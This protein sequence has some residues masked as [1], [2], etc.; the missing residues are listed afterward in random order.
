LSSY[1]PGTGGGGKD[2]SG[3]SESGLQEVVKIIHLLANSLANQFSRRYQKSKTPG[4]F[5]VRKTLRHNMRSGG[6]IMQLHFQKLQKQ[7]LHLILLCDVSKSM[8]LYS[9]F[10]VQFLYAFQNN[11]RQ[12]ETFVFSTSLHR[13][14]RELQKGDFEDILEQLSDQVPNWS[15]GTRIGASLHQFLEDHAGKHLKHRSIVLILS[16]GWD[17]GEVDLLADSMQR[18]K[19]KAGRIIWLNPLAGRPGY[20][21][22]VKGMQAAMPFIDVFAPA[23]NVASLREVV[24]MLK[25]KKQKKFK[26]NPPNQKS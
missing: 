2:F 1:S 23:H 3:F 14:S 7:K 26:L 9:R 12:I 24:K 5:D 11:Y 8:D 15:G 25:T 22:E 4:R 13:I 20:R 21:P 18:L 6:E 19:R 17:T 16:D 10:L